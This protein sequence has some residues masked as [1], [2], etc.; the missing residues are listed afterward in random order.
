VSVL[1]NPGDLL[2]NKNSSNQNYGV[3]FRTTVFAAPGST[4]VARGVSVYCIDHS[5]SGG[6]QQNLDDTP[7]GM[8]AAV[9]NLTDGSPLATSGTAAESRALMAQAGVAEDSDTAAVDA[10]A[11]GQRSPPGRPRSSRR[12]PWA[13]RTCR[14]AACAPG[15]ACAPTC[16]CRSRATPTGSR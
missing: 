16:W 1:A 11:V 13:T 14:P 15:G 4:T 12:R 6:M 10:D 7:I 2:L 5:L 8:L 3:G 9:W